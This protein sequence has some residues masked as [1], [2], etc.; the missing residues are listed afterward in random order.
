[1]EVVLS[2]AKA[3]PSRTGISRNVA[4]NKRGENTLFSQRSQSTKRRR[5][6]R[7]IECH[8]RQ[9]LEKKSK[10]KKGNVDRGGTRS[11]LSRMVEEGLSK[12]CSTHRDGNGGARTK[13][14]GSRVGMCPVYWRLAWPKPND[15]GERKEREQGC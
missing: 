7:K 6:T 1:M 14:L 10:S 13:C 4:L 15:W 9:Y 8:Y 2:N 12:A 11:G 3:L 5:A